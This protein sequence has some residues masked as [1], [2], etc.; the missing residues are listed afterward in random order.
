M[1]DN[2]LLPG[3]FCKSPGLPVRSNAAASS[4]CEPGHWPMERAPKVNYAVLHW[5]ALCQFDNKFGDLDCVVDGMGHGH[6]ECS[7]R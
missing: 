5:R 4:W 2:T 3:N 6:R 1:H 7:G